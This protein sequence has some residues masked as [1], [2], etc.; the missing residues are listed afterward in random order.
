MKKTLSLFIAT[1]L[2]AS[3][4]CISTTTVSANETTTPTPIEIDKDDT[5]Q[6]CSTSCII[7]FDKKSSTTARAQIMAARPGASS[8]TS[9]LQ[10]QKKSNGSWTNTSSKSTKTVQSTSINHIKTFTISSSNTYRLKATIKYVRDG[11]TLSNS[12]YKTL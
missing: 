12:Y 1:I 9:T 2:M 5:V 10:L 4:C 11:V 7:S 3:A 8:I 6:I